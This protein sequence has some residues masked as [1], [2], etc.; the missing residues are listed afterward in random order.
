[1]HMLSILLIGLIYA[2]T[3]ML[4]NDECQS[5]RE[6]MGIGRDK[7]G[8]CDEDCQRHLREYP[9][10]KRRQ[11]EE[12]AA[13]NVIQDKQEIPPLL[14]SESQQINKLIQDTPAPSLSLNEALGR[15]VRGI[16]A[17][18]KLTPNSLGQYVCTPP[19]VRII[20]NNQKVLDFLRKNQILY[21]FATKMAQAADANQIFILWSPS[22]VPAA[23]PAAALA[24]NPVV[25]SPAPAP[26]ALQ[27]TATATVEATISLPTLPSI[28][29]TKTSSANGLLSILCFAL[30]FAQ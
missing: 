27:P 12:Q 21:D 26:A 3:V 30:L 4:C 6:E 17:I 23:P 22:R 19:Q 11:A 1:M 8:I 13:G 24:P 15:F 7:D 10:F 18:L 16:I 28:A 14:T 25:S 5:K 20:Q 29:T 2:K 9:N